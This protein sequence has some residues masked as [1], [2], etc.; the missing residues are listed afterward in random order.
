MKVRGLHIVSALD[1][2]G[3]AKKSVKTKAIDDLEKKT[4][5]ESSSGACGFPESAVLIA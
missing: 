2:R 1:Q 3:R 4:H 5:A